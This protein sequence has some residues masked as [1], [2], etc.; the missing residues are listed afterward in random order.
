MFGGA[1]DVSLSPGD[2]FETSQKSRRG[3]LKFLSPRDPLI[4]EGTAASKLH[5][6]ES[7][8]QRG[9]DVDLGSHSSS[10]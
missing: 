9:C 2:G 5:L 6:R 7:R 3:V 1:V 8:A 4:G 10:G